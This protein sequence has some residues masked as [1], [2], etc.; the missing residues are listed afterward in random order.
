MHFRQSE[1]GMDN[2]TV[3]EDQQTKKQTTLPK[4]EI[5][6]YTVWFEC[7]GLILVLVECF[8]AVVEL[9]LDLKV[10]QVGGNVSTN[11]SRG[12]AP[13]SN[14]NTLVQ[15]LTA[16]STPN[17]HVTDSLHILYIVIL[18]LFMAEVFDACVVYLTLLITI[19]LHS[20]K[21]RIV[22]DAL[23]FLIGLRL[24][25]VSNII[26]GAS[27][28]ERKQLEQHIYAYRKARL[29][30]EERVNQLIQELSNKQV[31]N[32]KLKEIINTSGKTCNTS[33]ELIR[34]RVGRWDRRN[35]QEGGVSEF[36]EEHITPQSLRKCH[37]TLTG[38]QQSPSAAATARTGVNNSQNNSQCAS[39]RD[40]IDDQI[41][42]TVNSGGKLEVTDTNGDVI[43]AVAEVHS[44]KPSSAG[45]HNPTFI[46][47][48]EVVL[49]AVNLDNYICT[50]DLKEK[51]MVRSASQAS[52]EPSFYEAFSPEEM[53]VIR[54]IASVQKHCG[55]GV[56]MTSL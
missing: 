28:K 47:D 33:T 10:F 20:I 24:W 7:V 1:G 37:A 15:S 38:Q 42:D 55:E 22:R 4:L 32:E 36:H 49:S 50:G 31:E 34:K 18:I 40:S 8:L 5:Y 35:S 3:H 30:A 39:R 44:A 29:Y 27:V 13:T 53:E 21:L 48:K 17:A 25:K 23:A 43:Q 19:I 14:R 45:Y 46:N 12:S 41:S 26:F 11:Q 54:R 52:F 9:I 16:G 6:L 56:P 51:G 2:D